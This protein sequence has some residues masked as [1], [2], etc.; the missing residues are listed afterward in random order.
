MNAT[1]L[2]DGTVL[3]TG[4]SSGPGFSKSDV[5]RSTTLRSGTRRPK[6]GARRQAPR[7]LGSITPPPSCY[8][9][10]ESSRRADKARRPERS[11]R[12]PISSRARGR[13]LRS[14][15][16]IISHGQQF[17]VATPNATSI[18]KVHLIRLSSVTHG[19][20]RT[21]GSTGCSSLRAPAG[22]TSPR[23]PTAMSALPASTCCS[24]STALACP[25]SP[26]SC[27]LVL[28]AQRRPP[29]QAL[30]QPPRPVRC[31]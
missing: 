4:G 19:F 15:P 3:A 29:Q 5:F 17:F 28:Q 6:P 30:L 13:Q 31:R 10:V 8:P 18:T 21:S 26:R 27:G 22:S 11:I 12:R 1:I 2:A 25:P 20:N 24:S 23:P 7:G 9:T 16:D 14:A